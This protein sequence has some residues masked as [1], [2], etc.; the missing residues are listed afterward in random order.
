ME[1]F[2]FRDIEQSDTK[3]IGINS[4]FSATATIL[5]VLYSLNVN[6]IAQKANAPVY[7]LSEPDQVL[8]LHSDL[9]EISGLSY[10]EGKLYAVQDEKGVV[11]TLNIS[12]G[13][14][15][16]VKKCWKSGDY[17][18]IE[19]IDGFVYILKSNGNIYKSPL[20]DLSEATTIKID[21]G[22]DKDSNFE[23][24]A[25]NSASQTL[26]IA[27]KRTEY[28]N[29]KEI[30]CLPINKL[31]TISEPCYLVNDQMLQDELMKS[32]ISWSEKIA[33]K[34]SYS[35]NPSAIAVHP[36][37]GDIYILS[38]PVHQLLLLTKDWK[39]KK[40][41][42]LDQELYKQP[43]GICFDADL[44]LYIGNEARNGKARILKF[45]PR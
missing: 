21:L 13:D 11:Y 44:N 3:S 32:K 18:A 41:L 43:E 42:Q 9:D 8:T 40:I 28:T 35:F 22:L 7:H 19:V 17:E 30:Y 2:R 24:M 34:I 45:N 27:A 16:D 20:G 15:I 38:S 1:S 23:G 29:E 4:M 37:N 26:L 36:Q 5:I 33:H 39:F 12:T 31:G 10:Y 14:I 6:V 25:Y